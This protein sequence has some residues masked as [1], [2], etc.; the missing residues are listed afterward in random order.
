MRH[1]SRFI[2]LLAAPLL[3]ASAV[4][5]AHAGPRDQAAMTLVKTS[6]AHILVNAKGMTLYVFAKDSKN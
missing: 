2:S 5:G 3:L 4:A 1:S 6:P